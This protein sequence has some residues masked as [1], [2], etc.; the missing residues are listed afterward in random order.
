M[1]LALVLGG[2]QLGVFFSKTYQVNL[3]LY[4]MPFTFVTIKMQYVGQIDE[5]S[6]TNY[7][8]GFFKYEKFQ[9]TTIHKTKRPVF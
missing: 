3:V 6:E 5:I 4:K 8:H 9:S 2:N 1:D 7:L